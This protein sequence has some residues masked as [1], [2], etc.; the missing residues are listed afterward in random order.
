[1]SQGDWNAALNSG[2]GLAAVLSGMN[3]DVLL[4]YTRQVAGV[5]HQEERATRLFEGRKTR[6]EKESGPIVLPPYFTIPDGVSEK[7]PELALIL[8]AITE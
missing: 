5:R 6:G 4:S 7:E 1:M 8:T 2:E 3:A